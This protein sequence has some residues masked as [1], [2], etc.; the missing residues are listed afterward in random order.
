MNFVNACTHVYHAQGR[1]IRDQV[2]GRTKVTSWMF[3]MLKVG[4]YI[5]WG[6]KW[7]RLKCCFCFCV[8]L[9]ADALLPCAYL[10]LSTSESVSRCDLSAWSL[11]C[12]L[13][14]AR[15]LFRL[16]VSFIPELSWPTSV[17]RKVSQK[18]GL[19]VSALLKFRGGIFA[20]HREYFPT[21]AHVGA[22][23][24]YYRCASARTMSTNVQTDNRFSF[25]RISW[26][27]VFLVLHREIE[28]KPSQ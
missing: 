13:W 27:K 17:W 26:C 14:H 28:G 5:R 21:R 16:M 9:F 12:P 19:V 22:D 23:N 20:R 24:G 11:T 1:T 15:R 8:H 10:N 25:Y 18:S 2:R 7:H 3:T 4:V 6:Q